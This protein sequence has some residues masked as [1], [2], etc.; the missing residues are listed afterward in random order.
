MP[1]ACRPLWVGGLRGAR[2]LGARHELVLQRQAELAHRRRHRGVGQ[3]A[4]VAHVQQVEL[5]LLGTRGLGSGH[6]A[7][8]KLA[9]RA[10]A[11]AGGDGV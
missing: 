10:V 9:A 4:E 3:L 7:L 1:G 8:H 5:R 11:L 2:L 6:E